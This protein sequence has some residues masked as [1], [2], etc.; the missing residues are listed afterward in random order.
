M[1]KIERLFIDQNIVGIAARLIGL[2]HF[3]TEKI[4]LEHYEVNFE[5][6]PDKSQQLKK[7]SLLKNKELVMSLEILENINQKT[8]SFQVSSEKEFNFIYFCIIFKFFY[9][10]IKQYTNIESLILCTTRYKSYFYKKLFGFSTMG[11]QKNTFFLHFNT[12]ESLQNIWDEYYGTSLEENLY[13]FVLP[14]DAGGYVPGNIKLQKPNQ[15]VAA[16]DFTQTERRLC[17]N[18]QPMAEIKIGYDLYAI[19]IRDLSKTG[20]AFTSVQSIERPEPPQIQMNHIY[21]VWICDDQLNINWTNLTVQ[22]LWKKDNT[23]GC[24]ILENSAA[25]Q[26]FITSMKMKDYQ[27]LTFIEKFAT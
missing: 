16:N 15:K 19:S 12:N 2:Y 11:Y 10:Y 9:Q 18:E 20:V 13:N 1:T 8:L 5:N 4:G 27:R 23:F 22:I 7:V 17:S 14:V 3:T 6:K 25:W 26:T 21:S 24:R